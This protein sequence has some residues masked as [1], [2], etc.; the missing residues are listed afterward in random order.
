MYLVAMS[1]VSLLLI[2]IH[3]VLIIHCIRMGRVAH[4]LARLTRNMSVLV[5]SR[6]GFERDFTIELS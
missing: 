3:L 2:Y 5:G 4:W 1:V 6:N